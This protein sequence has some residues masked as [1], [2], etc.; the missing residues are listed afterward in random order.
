MKNYL[1]ALIMFIAINLV[2]CRPVCSQQTIINV[3]TSEVLQKDEI[4]LR[5]TSRFRPYNPDNFLLITPNATVGIGFNTELYA[6]P[7][8]LDLTDDFDPRFETA[9]KATF[10]LNKNFKI[11]LGSRLFISLTSA[12]TPFNIN[13]LHL[14][15]KI[16]YLK[17][18]ITAGTYVSNYKTFI[19][20]SV[21]AVLGYEQTILPKKLL[22]VIDWI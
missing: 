18:K 6:G 14:S 7:A 2:C 22:V 13:F 8:I 1:T 4:Y 9:I 11:T 15:A 17:S 19:P 3:P 16:P 21:G 12:K 10:N 5:I 20:G